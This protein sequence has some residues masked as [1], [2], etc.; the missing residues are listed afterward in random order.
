MRIVLDAQSGQR[1]REDPWVNEITN[2]ETGGKADEKKDCPK[3]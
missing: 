3:R 1:R 2:H